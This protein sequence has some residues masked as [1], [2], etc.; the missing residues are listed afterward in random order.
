M[1]VREALGAAM[2]GNHADSFRVFIRANMK[3]I[4]GAIEK[5]KKA[6]KA[7]MGVLLGAGMYGSTHG[8]HI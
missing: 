6:K 3:A 1:N 4:L 8:V 7:I 2:R 5:A